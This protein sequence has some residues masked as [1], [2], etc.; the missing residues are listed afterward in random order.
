MDRWPWDIQLILIP[1]SSFL[2]LHD[3]HW[4]VAKLSIQTGFLSEYTR[5]GL[6]EDDHL[7]KVKESAGAKQVCN[8]C[9]DDL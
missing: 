2:M 1:Y 9:H 6:L 7:K 4:Q 8:E 3:F 5:M